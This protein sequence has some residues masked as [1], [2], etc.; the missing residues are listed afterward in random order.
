ME[1]FDLVINCDLILSFDTTS[2][3][4][5]EHLPASLGPAPENYDKQA[6]ITIAKSYLDSKGKSFCIFDDFISKFIEHLELN[7]INLIVENPSYSTI[8]P[9]EYWI[10]I[11]SKSTKTSDRHLLFHR[12]IFRNLHNRE[13]GE[14]IDLQDCVK[15]S[16]ARI[17]NIFFEFLSLIGI[18]FIRMGEGSVLFYRILF[19]SAL[20]RFYRFFYFVPSKARVSITTWVKIVYGYE[21]RNPKFCLPLTFFARIWF[22]FHPSFRDI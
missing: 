6:W 3:L 11:H 5:P 14:Y 8:K 10:E 13:E 12:H 9:I 2:V 4:P 15:I 20:T 22:K 21:F 7:N 1:N 16:N 18:H 17:D 19:V